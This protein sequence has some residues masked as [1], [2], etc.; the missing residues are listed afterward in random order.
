MATPINIP[1]TMP[2]RNSL[3]MDTL[4]ATPKIIMPMDGGITGAM[5]P[6]EA[7]RPEARPML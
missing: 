1:G 6:P 4:P 3:V 7:I 5:M 2:A